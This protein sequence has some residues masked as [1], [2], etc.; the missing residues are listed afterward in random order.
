MLGDS[1]LRLTNRIAITTIA[2]GLKT[3]A[4]FVGTL[5]LANELGS[6][7][8]G[9]F[10]LA[11]TVI[12]WLELTD[13]GVGLAIQKRISE[14]QETESLFTAALILR[15][16]IVGAII[17]GLYLLQNTLNRYI[18]GKYGL[19]VVIMFAVVSAQGFISRVIVGLQW[20]HV[21]RITQAFER[22]SRS[23]LQIGLAVAGLG[24]F[25]LFYG[26]L[27]S[28]AVT[29]V[30]LT[31][32][33]ICAGMQFSLPSRRHFNSLLK[34]A[35]FSWLQRVR[36]R[37]FS[38][39][40]ISI[41]GFFVTQSQ[42][43]IY[44]VSWT[45]AATLWLF[46][47]SVSSNLF[48]EISY[49]STDQQTKRVRR[50]FEEGIIYSGIVP[51]A[52]LVGIALFG[53]RL[54]GLYGSE[55]IKGYSTLLALGV[56]AVSASYESQIQGL[57]DGLDRPD[58]TFQINL[59]SFVTN[60]GLNLL[61]IPTYGIWGAGIATAVA[62]TASLVY[63]L[64]LIRRTIHITLPVIEIGKQVLAA[65]SMGGILRWLQSVYYP[66]GLS[67]IFVTIIICAVVYFG[68]LLF[69][70]ATVREKAQSIISDTR[71]RL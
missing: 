56:L 25:A 27:V 55:F 24:T 47:R 70:S 2:D 69:V 41:L 4:G 61:L 48:P 12:K 17:I 35:K 64:F 44:Q 15:A 71:S 53:D 34:F 38:W 39:L 16:P 54:L 62:T 36:S 6:A 49:L 11:M 3:V 8:I 46:S 60:I 43:G 58:F 51:I 57:L 65:I 28:M 5:Y 30:L 67:E 45:L 22:V 33:L 14:F 10:A 31:I 66:R 7:S 52:G 9:T 26:Y 1:E 63:G 18:G 13:L 42:V 23:A 68:I 50:L 32:V 37:A 59:L 20:V 29:I 21:V 19:L 40:D